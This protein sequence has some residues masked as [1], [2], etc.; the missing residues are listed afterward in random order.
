M[1]LEQS[2][3]EFGGHAET[4]ALQTLIAYVRLSRMGLRTQFVRIV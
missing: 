2:Q 4:V 3:L 1:F